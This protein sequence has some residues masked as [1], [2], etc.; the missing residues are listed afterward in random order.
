MTQIVIGASPLTLSNL[1]AVL[2]APT[3]ISLTDRAWAAVDAGAAAVAAIIETGQ[4]VY[5]VNTGFGLL[6]NTR[7]DFTFHGRAAHAARVPVG[8]CPAPAIG[9]RS[10]ALKIRRGEWPG[11]FTTKRST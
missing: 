7:I 8:G 11:S 2:D 5:G 4:T 1:R 10:L 3:S 6:A 9:S